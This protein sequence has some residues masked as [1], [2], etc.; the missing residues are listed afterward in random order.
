MKPGNGALGGLRQAVIRFLVENVVEN[1]TF[2]E[3]D[4]VCVM[5]L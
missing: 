3:Q 2:G 5:A 4:E 1:V